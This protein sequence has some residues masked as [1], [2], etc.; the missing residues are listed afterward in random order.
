MRKCDFRKAKGSQ[1]KFPETD[2]H[3]QNLGGPVGLLRI[4][5]DAL[6][7]LDLC[8]V[9]WS[10]EPRTA[11]LKIEQDGCSVWALPRWCGKN[12][13]TQATPGG[14]TEPWHRSHLCSVAVA[15]VCLLHTVFFSWFVA[16]WK[17]MPWYQLHPCWKEEKTLVTCSH[18]HPMGGGGGG[19]KAP[20]THE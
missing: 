13:S 1:T 11:Y 17:K 12:S 5:D 20:Q 14:N 7:P 9:T 6:D 8:G 19:G 15:P 10:R 2:I 18:D 4:K 3:L 16:V